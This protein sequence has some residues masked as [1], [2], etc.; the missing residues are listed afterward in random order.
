LIFPHQKCREREAGRLQGTVDSA[1]GVRVFSSVV[2]LF[3]IAGVSFLAIE[4]YRKPITGR[5][6]SRLFCI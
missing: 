3:C 4:R 6:D 1:G 5:L 2:V